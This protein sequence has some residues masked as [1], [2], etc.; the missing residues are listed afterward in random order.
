MRPATLIYNASGDSDTLSPAD[1]TQLFSKVGYDLSYEP[2]EDESD[3]STA[4]R[5]GEGLVV[6]AGGD[7]TV[8]GV[9]CELMD[10]KCRTPLTILPMGTANN[11]AKTLGLLKDVEVLIEGLSEPESC[12]F[13]V[14][15][16]EAPWGRDYFIEGAGLGLYADMLTHYD[17]E[18]GKSVFRALKTVQAIM[19]DSEAREVSYSLDGKPL[20]GTFIALEILNTKAIGPRLRLAP[21]ASPTDGL[22]DVAE[23]RKPEDVTLAD[24]GL[25]LLNNSFDTLEN[26]T[27]QRGTTIEITWRGE[28]FHVDAEVRPQQAKTLNKVKGETLP[29]EGSVTLSNL[30]GALELWLPSS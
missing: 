7:G 22:F 25:S 23:V 28:P 2:T 3:L 14:G 8:R 16:V 5:Q 17:P 30:A 24:Y 27:I 21:N 19:F 10:S 29:T 20:S 4:L 6:V 9:I 1:L 13:D 15:Q 26:V 12:G 18:E 11:I